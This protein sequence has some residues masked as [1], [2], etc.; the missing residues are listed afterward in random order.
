MQKDIVYTA[1][2][3]AYQA[4]GFDNE[5]EDVSSSPLENPTLNDVLRR[6][7]QYERIRHVS[8]VAAR[9]R[10]LLEMDLFLPT[11]RPVDLLSLVRRGLIIDLHN[12]YAETLQ[13]AAGAF[14]LRKLYRDMFRWGTH[15]S[16]D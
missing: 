2:R 12:L 10:S 9:C 5:S 6:I 13:I 8:N 14:V 3:D 4:Q 1:V 15:S 7:E 11:E 16:S